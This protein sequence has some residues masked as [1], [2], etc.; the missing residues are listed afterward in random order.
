MRTLTLFA[1]LFPLVTLGAEIHSGHASA[2]L[3]VSSST[4]QP[5]SPV[6][7]AIRLKVDQGWHTY[8]INPGEGGM[9]LGAEWV[10]PEGWSAGPLGWPVPIRFKTGDL[11]G[12]GYVGELVIPVTLTPPASATK[13]ATLAV[14]LDWLTCDDKACIS[15]E[16]APSVELKPGRVNATPS[17]PIIEKSRSLVPR[18]LDGSKLEVSD[19][20][21][22][23]LLSLT[24]PAGIDPAR[25]ASFP[26][27][28][29]V[30]DA[31]AAIVFSKSEGKWTALVP[32]SEYLQGP[33]TALDLVLSGGGL[34]HPALLSWSK[35]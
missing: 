33:P 13:A 24:V 16:A 21:K 26:A 2:E 22:S 6:Q 9:K 5:S 20:G 10:L 23:L 7:A 27:S 14:K 31:S 15:G 30:V 12:F 3:L 32:K 35:K 19:Q 18:P 1:A 28:A 11:P 29:Q 34:A 8:W 25:F 17:A 4:F